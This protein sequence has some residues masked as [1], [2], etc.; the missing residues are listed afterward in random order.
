MAMYQLRSDTE[1]VVTTY[2]ESMCKAEKMFHEL[3]EAEQMAMMHI[4]A[5]ANPDDFQLLMRL[6]RK[7]YFK[8]NH[9]IEE[10]MYL[11][12]IRR[13][14]LIQ[15]LDKFKDVLVIVEMQDPIISCFYSQ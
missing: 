7:G 1:S 15:L 9:H 8:G 4:P 10:I 11:Q 5:T 3:D 12:N 6:L 2:S 13:S 14:D